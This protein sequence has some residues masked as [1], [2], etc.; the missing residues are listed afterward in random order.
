MQAVN[1]GVFSAKYEVYTISTPLA[2]WVVTRRWASFS[3]L[4][5]HL[6][7]SCPGYIVPPLPKKPVKSFTPELMSERKELLQLFLNDVLEHPVLREAKFVS[8]FLATQDEKVYERLVKE[9]AR[10]AFH[11]DAVQVVTKD[12]TANV[13]ITNSLERS[14]NEIASGSKLV[15]LEFKV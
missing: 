1:P 4:R 15:A 13:S 14:V 6:V 12:S 7:K 9:Y 2:G 10:K 11:K 3:E 8:H 5:E